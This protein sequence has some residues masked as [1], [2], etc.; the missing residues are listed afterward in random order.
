MYCPF[1]GS[2]VTAPHGVCGVCGRDITFLKD[3]ADKVPEEMPTTSAQPSTSAGSS[4]VVYLSREKK[5]KIVKISVGV[6]RMMDG[7]LRPV[8]GRLL[9]LDVEPQWSCQELLA[10]AIKNQ[11]DFKQVV[12]DGAHVLLY[13]DAREITNIPGT[14]IPFTVE[15][16][17]KTSGKPYQ[18][19]AL[20]I[21][22]VEDLEN[23]C[24]AYCA[25][26]IQVL[27]DPE[28][29]S[30]RVEYKDTIKELYKLGLKP[31]LL[32]PAQLRLTLPGGGRKWISSVEEAKKYIATLQKSSEPQK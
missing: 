31:A 15:M 6:M 10:A 19:I 7:F 1:C 23:S 13:P 17:K 26:Q 5:Q 18:R 28:V 12:E 2:S 3:V 16:Y 29:M 21:C 25:Q 32:F 14:D 30:Q 27:K 9:P 8:R 24:V 4:A 22:T 20:Y 11:K